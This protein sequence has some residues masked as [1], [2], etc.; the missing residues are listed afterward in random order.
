MGSWRILTI[1]NCFAVWYVEMEALLFG[2]GL[3]RESETG[4]E[5][6]MDAKYLEDVKCSWGE[7]LL[8]QL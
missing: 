8:K 1:L 7:L 3:D 5:L 2:S 6:P 4:F